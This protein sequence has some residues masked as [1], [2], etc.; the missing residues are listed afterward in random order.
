MSE[1]QKINVKSW[2]E[3]PFALARLDEIREVKE[4][5]N[6]RSLSELLFR[7]L[8]NS[9]WTLQTTLE[10]SVDADSNQTLLGYYRRMERSKP[11][12]ESFTNRIWESIPNWPAF[13]RTLQDETAKATWIDKILLDNPAIYQYMIYLRHH[14]FPSPILDW[15]AS[16][17]IAAMFAFDSIDRSAKDVAIHIYGRDSIQSFGS[18]EHLFIVGPYLRTHRRHYLQQ[19]RYSMCLQLQIEKQASLQYD[20]LFVPHDQAFTRNVNKDLLAKIVI[21]ASERT[22]AL[23]QLDSMNINPYSLYGSEESLIR[24]IARREMLFKQS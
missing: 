3:F 15:T 11:V 12:V 1:L 8:G 24:T 7:G 22:P 14:S 19:S 18:D 21:P 2:D 13:E 4:K 17:F 6:K 16:P 20:Y 5:T 9:L 23:R 10:R